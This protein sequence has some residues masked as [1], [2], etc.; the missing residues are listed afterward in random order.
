MNNHQYLLIIYLIVVFNQGEQ[1]AKKSEWI[2][3]I[4]FFGGL[5]KYCSIDKVK[6]ICFN[7]LESKSIGEDQY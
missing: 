5:E 3:L 6:T 2:L 7:V 4:I 1:L